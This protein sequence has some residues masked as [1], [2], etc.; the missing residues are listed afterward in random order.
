VVPDNHTPGKWVQ[1]QA[2]TGSLSALPFACGDSFKPMDVLIALPLTTLLAS[3]GLTTVALM[4]AA[5]GALRVA[6][7]HVDWRAL[8][9]GG[10]LVQALIQSY[11]TLHNKFCRPWP[12]ASMRVPCVAWEPG[13]F[14]CT[15]LQLCIQFLDWLQVGILPGVVGRQGA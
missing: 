13:N 12:S 3:L 10:L 14:E 4:T 7:V 2:G 6:C 15:W 9:A 5:D 11:W 8:P 1:L